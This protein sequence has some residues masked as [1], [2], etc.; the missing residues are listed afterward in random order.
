MIG[1]HSGM[2]NLDELLA[3]MVWCHALKSDLSYL[4]GKQHRRTIP[5]VFSLSEGTFLGPALLCSSSSPQTGESSFVVP[6]C[7]DPGRCFHMPSSCKIA[8][9]GNQRPWLMSSA[10]ICPADSSATKFKV[11]KEKG[12][13]KILIVKYKNKKVKWLQTGFNKNKNIFYL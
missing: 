3:E 10:T 7:F 1:F 6:R 2:T 4:K 9:H 12:G 11:F 5:S 13:K 8:N